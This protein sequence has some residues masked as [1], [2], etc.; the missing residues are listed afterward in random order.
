MSNYALSLKRTGL[1]LAALTFTALLMVVN[2]ASFF[3]TASAA[4]LTSRSLT[5]SSSLVGTEAGGSAGDAINGAAATHTFGFT[6]S[7]GGADTIR[8]DY[9]T[10]AIGPCTAPTGL[11]LTGGSL[12]GQSGAAS[13]FGSYTVGN[14]PAGGTN[15]SISISGGALTAAAATIVFGD[16]TNPTTV[17]TFF[18]RIQTIDAD[19]PTDIDEGTVASSI[20]A[21][22]EIT[23]RVA[24]TL[25]F[26]TTG[27]FTGVGDPG[28]NCAPVTGSGAIT[29][30]D[31]TE[32]T[33]S[34]T[35]AYDNYSAFRLYTNAAGGV[36]VQY[37]GETL[38]RSAGGDIDAIGGTAEASAAEEQ[39]GLAIDDSVGGE[40]DVDSA[41][42]EN[43]NMQ[44]VTDELDFANAGELSFAAEYGGGEGTLTH[45][46][47]TALFAF[48][49]NTPTT[50]ASTLGYTECKTAAVRY[51]ANISPTTTSG[52]YTTTIVYSAVPTY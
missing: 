25:G 50:I 14:A 45:G 13:G 2:L 46:S 36:V 26:S 47:G 39:F 20:T 10:T 43:M 9:C 15:N 49:P 40:L 12:D 48:E 6:A 27:A 22:I 37:T 5:L 51:I 31:P 30:G 8:F 18:V 44:Y 29:L 33:L 41:S 28:S 35:Q 23:A 19:G 4:D 24:E 17:G 21:G 38:T 34:L 11:V 42:R 52:T 7:T 32:N 1:L 16:I 3:G